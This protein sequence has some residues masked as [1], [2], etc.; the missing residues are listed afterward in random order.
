[1]RAREM[2]EGLLQVVCEAERLVLGAAR[3]R[4]C[5]TRVEVKR[6][7]DNSLILG[8]IEVV[9]ADLSRRLCGCD[10]AFVFAATVGVGADRAIRTAEVKSPLLS[11]ACDSA[12][13][14][15]VEELCDAI[16]TELAEE[17]K[18]QGRQTTK[19]FSAGYGD[20]SLEYQR[21]ICR[22]LD[23]PRNIGASLTDGVMMTPSKTVTA[24]VGIR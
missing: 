22:L 2:T 24:I 1:M 20:L 23:T 15:L 19:R 6:L 5:W 13:S 10:E 3:C 8:D 12:G 4:T 7:S 16:N 9:S 11:L 17:A 14:A 21:Q 18:K